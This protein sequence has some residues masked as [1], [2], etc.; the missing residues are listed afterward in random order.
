MERERCLVV[1]FQEDQVELTIQEFRRKSSA[2]DKYVFLQSLQV[3]MGDAG[4]CFATFGVEMCTRLGV[5]GE[6]VP[7]VTEVKF[8]FGWGL[9]GPRFPVLRF[10]RCSQHQ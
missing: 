1:A 6:E 5:Y 7:S 9:H 2:L 3:R 4:R 8:Q 10:A